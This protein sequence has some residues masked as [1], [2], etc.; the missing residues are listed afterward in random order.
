MICKKCQA[1][2]PDDSRFC[3]YCGAKQ[4]EE[5]RERR[6]VRKRANGTGTAYKQHGRRR[7]P[8]I[9]ERNKV[10]IGFYETKTEALEALARYAGKEINDKF[11]FSFL[12][13]YILWKEEHFA[14][15][16][17]RTQKRYETCFSAFKKLHNKKFRDLRVTDF[18]RIIDDNKDK[19]DMVRKYR[20]LVSMLYK[21][22]MREEIVNNNLAQFINLPSIEKKEKLVFTPDEI[23]RID[24]E[25]SEAARIVSMLISTGMRIG[26][27]FSL[28]LSNYHDTYVIGGSKTEAGRNRIIPIRP[29]GRR[30]FAY[31]AQRS[32]GADLLIDSYT[33]NKD[34]K[35]FRARDYNNL[36]K[37]LCIDLEKTPHCTRHTYASRAIREGM[38]PE[39]L[40]KILGHTDFSTTA[41]IYNHI[42]AETLVQSVEKCAVASTLLARVK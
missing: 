11:N 30:H 29:E 37:K 20:D 24:D 14:T 21:W 22:A 7:R 39:V 34:A 9:A 35:N 15:I 26:E 25:G 31:F 36:L 1:T 10:V 2:L 38:K 5:K 17:E 42:D 41:N 16:D 6:K 28:K 4:V 13:V 32:Q 12:D 23:Q 40:Q 3:S 8:W 33:G 27:L 19:K 18:Q